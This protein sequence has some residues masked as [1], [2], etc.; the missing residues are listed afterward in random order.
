[1][2]TT[3]WRLSAVPLAELNA[4]LADVGFSRNK[5]KGNGDCYVLSAMAGFEISSAAAR[6]P[7]AAATK[8]VRAAR[9]GA[10][11]ILTG[12]AAVDGIDAA[13]L[14][15]SEYLPVDG[16][17]AREAIGSWLEPG[18][19]TNGDGNNSMS[20]MLGVALHLQRPV[21]VI[22]R[23]GAT[24][25]N[26]ARIYGARDAD[27]GLIHTVAKPNAP[28]TIPTFKL[29]PIADLLETLRTSPASCSVVEYNGSNHFDPWGLKPSLHVAAT[30]PLEAAVEEAHGPAFEV[31]VDGDE[32]EA[33][34]VDDVWIP[35]EGGPFTANLLSKRRSTLHEREFG[36]LVPFDP[37]RNPIYAGGAIR[38]VDVPGAPEGGITCHLPSSWEADTRQLMFRLRLSKQ[39]VTGDKVTINTVLYRKQ[40]GADEDGAS[41]DGSAWGDDVAAATAAIKPLEGPGSMAALAGVDANKLRAWWD[42]NGGLAICGFDPE[43]WALQL[44][45]RLA[46]AKEINDAFKVNFNADLVH[47]SDEML[48]SFDDGHYLVEMKKLVMEQ[49]AP[50]PL[51]PPQAPPPPASVRPPPALLQP[52]PPPPPPPPPLLPPLPPPPPPPPQPQPPLP[53]RERKRKER[54]G[55]NG[56]FD[57][58]ASSFRSAP[59]AR[60]ASISL[61]DETGIPGYALPP[62][63]LWAKG[64]HAGEH[65]WFKARVVK[66]RVKFPRIHVKFLEDEHGSTHP[67]ALPELDAYLH[68]ADVR[69]RDW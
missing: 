16:A 62:N 63:L 35:I 5:A 33:M 6:V 39:V 31:E 42:A 3:S 47:L 12:D 34:L 19:W 13:V 67:L 8:S 44:S 1:M 17:A 52:P 32:A 60:K 29:M 14:R 58:A 69:E 23:K 10:I 36:C 18:F 55:D 4:R 53:R 49:G 24:F 37:A 57:G 2:S 11:G 61:A 28:E 45:A 56:E 59:V 46:A 40:R 50:Q 41:N 48:R 7:K 68:A 27:G 15:N 25:L 20:F 64:W 38:F 51:P 26:P 66:L 43:T 21:A 30:A 54:F 65:A 22:E 9:E